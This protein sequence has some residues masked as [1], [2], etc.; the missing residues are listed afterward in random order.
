MTTFARLCTH[1]LLS[2]PTQT[3]MSTPYIPEAP[4]EIA[5]RHLTGCCA[6]PGP[7]VDVPLPPL[8]RLV[9]RTIPTYAN[10]N[11]VSP[12]LRALAHST[13]AFIFYSKWKRDRDLEASGNT[14]TDAILFAPFYN[15]YWRR[16]K[17]VLGRAKMEYVSG[18][19]DQAMF[20]ALY[21]ANE[22]A[23]LGHVP[24]ALIELGTTFRSEMRPQWQ[25]FVVNNRVF[26]DVVQALEDYEKFHKGSYERHREKVANNT[27]AYVC[28]AENCGL[29]GLQKRALR[30]CKGSC[31]VLVKPHYCSKECQRNDWRRHKAICSAKPGTEGVTSP[32]SSGSA[33][34]NTPGPAPTSASAPAV[35]SGDG[36]ALAPHGELNITDADLGHHFGGQISEIDIGVGK[37]RTS[38]D[39]FSPHALREVSKATQAEAFRDRE[40]TTQGVEKK[41]HS[42]IK[43]GDV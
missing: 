25:R 29:Q 2:V 22:S 41:S 36:G 42:D 31:P 20:F 3:L 33:N 5:F 18:S 9:D 43:D 10:D 34:V 6:K 27:Q 15:D 21:H 19:A 12:Q 17:S 13:A 14:Y 16:L 28:A 38:S 40:E 30:A 37:L 7:S 24:T 11:K 1:F 32:Q 8:M 4:L 35:S 23:R 26:R 39:C